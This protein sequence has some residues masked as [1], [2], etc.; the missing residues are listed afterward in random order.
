MSNLD[1]SEFSSRYEPWLPEILSGSEY[2]AQYEEHVDPFTAIDPAADYPVRAAVRYAIHENVRIQML[3]TLFEGATRAG[4]DVLLMGELFSQYHRAYAE[5]GLGSHARDD[6]VERARD[7]GIP[8]AKMTGGGGGGVVA[9][10]GY[11]DDDA[12]V[13]AIAEAHAV[14]CDTMPLVFEGSSDGVDASGVW[15]LEPSRAWSLR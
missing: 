3:R 6:L 15:I 14:D 4:S 11:S 1:P 2:L 12:R 8:A 7:A 5:C 10:L 13:R 9:V